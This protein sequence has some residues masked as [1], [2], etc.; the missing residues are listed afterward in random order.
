MR[1]KDTKKVV[2]IITGKVKNNF[3]N[4]RLTHHAGLG[5]HL[6]LH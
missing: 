2:E 5:D 3:T 6:G 1:D 4:E